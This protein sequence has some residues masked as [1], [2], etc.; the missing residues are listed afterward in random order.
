MFS[1]DNYRPGIGPYKGQGGFAG[2]WNKKYPILATPGLL[3]GG[4]L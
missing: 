1:T 2:P 3:H 4:W